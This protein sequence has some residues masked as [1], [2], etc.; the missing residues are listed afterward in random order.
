MLSSLFTVAPSAFGPDKFADLLVH[1]PIF[2][3]FWSP[4]ARH[5]LLGEFG[6]L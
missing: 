6:G 2:G 1:W 4:T 5:G 3:N